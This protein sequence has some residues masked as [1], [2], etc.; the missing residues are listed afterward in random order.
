[1]HINVTEHIFAVLCHLYSSERGR[2][3]DF[4]LFLG[5][6]DP[7]KVPKGTQSQA[8][9]VKMWFSQP[10]LLCVKIDL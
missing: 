7:F 10:V 6:A 8:L 2:L 1:M 3:Y 5:Q 9:D 4:I